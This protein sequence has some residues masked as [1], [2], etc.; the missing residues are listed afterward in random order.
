MKPEV[1]YSLYLCT[2]R[3]LM[4]AA[5]VEESVEQAI[6]GGCTLIQLREKDISSREFYETALAV[7]KVTE[8]YHVPLIIND[9]LDIALAVGADGVHVGQS[10]LPCTVLRRILG[11]EKIIGVSASTLEEA[12]QAE[13]DGADYL[14]VG[15]MYATGTK[16][17]AVIV[18]MQKLCAIREAVKIPIVVI[19]G[20]NLKTA[21]AFCN[22]GIDGLSVVSAVIAQPDI[23][24]AARGLLQIF[25]GGKP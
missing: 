1:D 4:T 3:E 9:R 8:H 23:R 10:D 25:Q 19:G 18:S 22:I 20:I 11:E 24:E 16:T 17:D 12:V 15:A 6:L 2:D 13:K 21:P 7:K 14:G 5:T